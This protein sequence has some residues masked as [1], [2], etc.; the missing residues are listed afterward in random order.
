VAAAAPPGRCDDVAAVVVTYR[1]DG[2]ALERLLAALRGQVG[3]VVVVDNEST[4]AVAGRL[5]GAGGPCEL[6]ANAQNLGIATAQNQ[7]IERAL[8]HPDCEYV[9]FLDQ[10]S[11]PEEGMVACLRAALQPA[12]SAAG[13]GARVAAAGPLSVDARTGE[14]AWVVVERGG[15]PVRARPA[16]GDAP[17]GVAFLL[18]SG[19]LV[20]RPVLRELRG[21]RGAYFIDHV[22]TEWCLRARAAGCRLLV[23]PAARL[24]HRLGDSVRKVW[25]LGWRS[26]A[27]HSPLRDYYMFRNTLLMLRDVPM[28]AAWRRHFLRRLV[29]FAGYF[30]AVAPARR[31][32]W[33]MMRLG[34][35]HGAAGIGGRLDEATG[36]C[37]ALP[38]TAADPVAPA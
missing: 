3:R 20:P 34:L 29:L 37:E 32:R 25:L 17:L 9:L 35:R 7:G 10:D 8:A 31:R 6:V 21:M 19:T 5:A 14:R 22:D 27:T 4:G 18:A 16:P 11:L 38:A 2:A 36:R 30:L 24:R 15:R 28:P 12:L 13:G 26:V 1:P 33:A 23:V